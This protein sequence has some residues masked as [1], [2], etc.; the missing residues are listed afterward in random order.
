MKLKMQATRKTAIQRTFLRFGILSI[1]LLMGLCA[2]GQSGSW[3]PAAEQEILHLLNQERTQRGLQPLQMLPQLVA[4]ARRHSAWMAAQHALSHQFSGEPELTARLAPAN[5]H[6]DESGE[7]VAVNTS[8]AGAHRG[9]MG[10]PPHREN[11][12]NARYNVI[13]IGVMRAGQQIWVTQD[14]A[15]RLPDVSAAEAEAQVA[16]QFNE[17]RRN[18]RA[19]ALPL[20]ENPRLRKLACQMAKRDSLNTAEA[21][22]LPR[23]ARVVTFTVANLTRMPS[24]LQN[25][26]TVPASGFSV[27]ACYAG[28]RTYASPVYWIILTTY[29]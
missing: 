18:A 6:F 20:I 21:G 25:M 1:V 24:Y 13:G 23:V 10:S 5:I 16:R 8:A 12:L 17:L 27:G 11:I 28:S 29:F 22:S 7:N 4:V 26:R 14:F 2:Y 3:D 9:L 19:S 15:E